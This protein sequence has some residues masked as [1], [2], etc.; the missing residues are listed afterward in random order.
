MVVDRSAAFHCLTPTPGRPRPKHLCAEPA[1]PPDV[2]SAPFAG[3]PTAASP[4]FC[5]QPPAPSLSQGAPANTQVRPGYTSAC[6]PVLQVQAG[7]PRGLTVP[8]PLSRCTFP[9]CGLPCSS[10]SSPHPGASVQLCSGL[11]RLTPSPRSSLCSGRPTRPPH[12]PGPLTQLS[13]DPSTRP[14]PSAT[15]SVIMP[16]CLVFILFVCSPLSSGYAGI[17]DCFF[18]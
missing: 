4:C 9:S 12:I 18:R 8:C 3:I 13:F 5:S 6:C 7:F 16:H 10:S 14:S 11:P 17:L 2:P 1:G 15:H